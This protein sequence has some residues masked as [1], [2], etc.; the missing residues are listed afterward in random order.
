MLDSVDRE[1]R[2]LSRFRH[3]NIIQL[4]GFSIGGSE[5]EDTYLIYQYAYRGSLSK[6]LRSEKESVELEHYYRVD[7]ALGVARALHYMHTH[8]SGSVSFHR[9]VKSNNIVLTESYQPKLIDCGLSSV[10]EAQ[11]MGG[12]GATAIT[13]SS[14]TNTSV[15]RSGTPGYVCPTYSG[16]TT[17]EFDARCEI[18]S[19]G[20]VLIELLSGQIQGHHSPLNNKASLLPNLVT[21][22]AEDERIRWPSHVTNGMRLLAARCVAPYNSRVV[23]LHE[24]I[25]ALENLQPTF[26][27]SS[28]L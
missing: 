13:K 18:Y 7:I 15:V 1:I 19:F 25:V 26:I 3:E 20:V 9:D 14:V 2:T 4:L 24:A 23:S 8:P 17:M 21:D 27:P 12:E 28:F 10:S 22:I 6:V 11:M 16:S 5:L